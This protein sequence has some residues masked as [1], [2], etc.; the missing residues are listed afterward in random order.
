MKL[1]KLKS[2]NSCHLFMVKTVSYST[3]IGPL[4][5]LGRAEMASS[6]SS[7]SSEVAHRTTIILRPPLTDPLT[8]TRQMIATYCEIIIASDPNG[9]SRQAH[10]YAKHVRKRNPQ[11]LPR[12]FEVAE[13]LH[14]EVAGERIKQIL[15]LSDRQTGMT[16]MYEKECLHREE[17]HVKQTLSVRCYF[18]THAR[19]DFS[20]FPLQ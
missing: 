9:H 8:I 2:S 12:R 17:H 15:L 18:I 14:L 7:S 6:G 11:P 4:C 1:A 16:A 13:S 19:N 5:L 20:W 10:I 3:Q